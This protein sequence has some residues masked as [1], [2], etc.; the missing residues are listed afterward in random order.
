MHFPLAGLTPRVLA[1]TDPFIPSGM[2]L[3][4]HRFSRGGAIEICPIFELIHFLQGFTSYGYYKGYFA[5]TL[6]IPLTNAIFSHLTWHAVDLSTVYEQ[7]VWKNP[8]KPD[9]LT[10]HYRNS[11]EPFAVFLRLLLSV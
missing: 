6:S 3:R 7:N 4:C 5:C 10:N 9:F 11:P 1:G 8:K 2:S